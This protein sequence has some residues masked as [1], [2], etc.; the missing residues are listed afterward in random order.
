V[1]LCHRDEFDI[2]Y[3]VSGDADLAPAVDIVVS[4]GKQVINVYLEHPGGTP[5]LFGLTAWGISGR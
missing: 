4:H 1:D 2:A 5:M 3:L